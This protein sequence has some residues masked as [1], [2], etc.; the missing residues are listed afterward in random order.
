[1][2]ATSKLE[3]ILAAVLAWATCKPDIM[4][5]ALVGSYAQK[6]A[7][8]DSDID[9]VVLTPEPDAFRSSQTWPHEV[10]WSLV[11]S[12]VKEWQDAQ[13]G[14]AWS[15]HVLLTAGSAVEFCFVEPSWVAVEPIDPGT[16]DVIAGGCRV[17]L[18]REHYFERLINHAV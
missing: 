8:S 11:P 12:S 5:V 10:D 14:A 2:T 15:R 17:L 18:D 16:R 6:T 4:G 1:M 7:H 3:P 13:Y 9:L